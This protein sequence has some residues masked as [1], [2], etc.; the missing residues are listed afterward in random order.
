MIMKDL[1]TC[2]SKSL[3]RARLF[4]ESI[5]DINPENADSL[6]IDSAIKSQLNAQG[7]KKRVDRLEIQGQVLKIWANRNIGYQNYLPEDIQEVVQDF[8]LDHIK[9]VIIYQDLRVVFGAGPALYLSP[10]PSSGIIKWTFQ[11]PGA[12]IHVFA[13]R[14]GLSSGKNLELI[15]IGGKKESRI[16][17]HASHQP[18]IEN[19][20][21]QAD[22]ITLESNSDTPPETPGCSFQAREMLEIINPRN[23][24]WKCL[25]TQ[26]IQTLGLDK[27]GNIRNQDPQIDLGMKDIINPSLHPEGFHSPC[28]SLGYFSQHMLLQIA[29]DTSKFRGAGLVVRGGNREIPP[30][31]KLKKDGWYVASTSI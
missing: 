15:A 9:E 21:A 23:S 7:S 1:K 14:G 29:Q 17:F 18:K 31:M 16:E 12:R 22:I 5:L 27:S 6:V 13:S 4:D 25:T 24:P 2:L 11:A 20:K 3:Y 26:A 19:I 28:I 30:Y 10:S 8:H